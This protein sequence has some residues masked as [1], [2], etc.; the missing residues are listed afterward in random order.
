MS[1]VYP[2]LILANHFFSRENDALKQVIANFYKLLLF[3]IEKTIEDYIAY[4]FSAG[5][6]TTFTAKSWLNYHGPVLQANAIPR[7]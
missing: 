3:S 2:N 6:P 1:R 7:Y 5:S 4:V